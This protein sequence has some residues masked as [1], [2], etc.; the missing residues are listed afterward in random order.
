MRRTPRI[1][2]E[3][4]EPVVPQKL[5]NFNGP[6]MQPGTNILQQKVT[7]SLQP[8]FARNIPVNSFEK[9]L[10]VQQTSQLLELQRM[11]NMQKNKNQPYKLIMTPNQNGLFMPLMTS[12]Q[13]KSFVPLTTQNQNKSFIPL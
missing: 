3:I 4:E 6:F 8:S 1:V 2:G 9:P 11:Q 12:N 10:S 5:E 7:Q 13:N